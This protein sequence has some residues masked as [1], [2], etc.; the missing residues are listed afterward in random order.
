VTDFVCQQLSSCLI[1]EMLLVTANIPSSLILVTLMMEAIRS[2]E[3]SVL[4]RVTSQKM[5]FFITITVLFQAPLVPEG[6]PVVNALA[7]Q[8]SCIENVL[9]ACLGLPPENNMLLE[10]KLHHPLIYF[11]KV[12]AL[13]NGTELHHGKS[14]TNGLA[15]DVP[16]QLVDKIHQNG[17]KNYIQG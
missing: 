14:I 8:R 3:M 1:K 11:G 4:T 17:S 9:R 16:K 10:H 2:S 13:Q 15:G 5:A 12:P 6:T 7:K